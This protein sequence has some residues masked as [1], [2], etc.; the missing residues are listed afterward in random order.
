LWENVSLAVL[1][2]PNLLHNAL[3]R[4]ANLPEGLYILY[5]FF[6]PGSAYNNRSA[7]TLEWTDEP[8][9][10]LVLDEWT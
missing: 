5:F 8:T 7:W 2:A 4:L 1:Y 10:L 9:Y 3:A 6:K